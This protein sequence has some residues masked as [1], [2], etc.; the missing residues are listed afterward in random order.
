MQNQNQDRI[1]VS[2]VIERIV[3]GIDASIP[4][5][6]REDPADELTEVVLL[7]IG[8]GM[9]LLVMRLKE[10][11]GWLRLATHYGWKAHRPLAEYVSSV[12]TKLSA[13]DGNTLCA[14]LPTGSRNSAIP[15][16]QRIPRVRLCGPSIQGP[17]VFERIRRGNN[18]FHSAL[19][20]LHR[21]VPLCTDAHNPVDRAKPRNYNYGTIN[22]PSKL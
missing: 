16:I 11:K 9:R 2:R 3:A 5:D 20:Q 22:D 8:N 6:L 17:L 21:R 18:G 1:N 19:N 7:G 14:A 4:D 15:A 12:E 13:K 10:W